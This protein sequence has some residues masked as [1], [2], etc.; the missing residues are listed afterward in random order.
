MRL[1]ITTLALS[2]FVMV[3]STVGTYASER[4]FK[5]LDKDGNGKV[6]LE[7]F[8]AKGKEAKFRTYDKNSDGVITLDEVASKAKKNIEVDQEKG[9]GNSGNK[10]ETGD[11]PDDSLELSKAIVYGKGGTRDLYLD[12]LRP[13]QTGKRVLPVIIWIHG[14]AWKTGDKSSGMTMLPYLAKAGYLC[15]MVQYR[16]CSEAIFPA[17]IEDCKCAVRFLRAHSRK[18]GLNPDKIGVWGSSAGG[19][20]AALIGTSGGVKELEG[21]GGWKEFSSS[22]QAVC[23]FM[24]PTDL[25]TLAK[26]GQTPG[27]VTGLLG[28]KVKEKPLL[29]ALASPVTH[30]DKMDPPF[31]II[32]GTSDKTVP[33]E[34]SELLR[35]ALDKAKVPT[36]LILRA[37]TGHARM[38]LKKN[39][40]REVMA[41][42]DKHLK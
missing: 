39:Y 5:Q 30:V 10:P 27:N 14:G 28:G 25:V 17:Q 8:K 32:H 22:V 38:T 9:D 16:F 21:N 4:L 15:V 3:G 18:Y 19:H 12:I 6:T 35:S 26:S 7:E 23:D 37:K 40:E 41:F 34:Q 13:K 31:L 1:P 36:E 11:A 24:G 29:A 20:L 33:Y 2:V 42:F